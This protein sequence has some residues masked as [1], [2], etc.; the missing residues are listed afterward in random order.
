MS[1]WIQKRFEAWLFHSYIYCFS[2][3]QLLH[4]SIYQACCSLLISFYYVLMIF[5]RISSAYLSLCTLNC[6]IS[7]RAFSKFCSWPQ[8]F[9]IYLT[10][11]ALNYSFSLYFLPGEPLNLFSYWFDY[12][13]QCVFWGTF[14]SKLLFARS[15]DCL[16]YMSDF[17][18]RFLLIF[19]CSWSNYFLMHLF[20]FMFYYIFVQRSCSC[21]WRPF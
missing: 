10:P 2:W 3:S 19:L 4:N 13:F 21:L 16:Y 5:S 9:L 11:K 14:S 15:S 18:V 6:A 8:F 17:S 20:S 1:L 7:H 12:C